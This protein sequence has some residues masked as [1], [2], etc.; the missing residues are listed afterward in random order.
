MLWSAARNVLF[1]FFWV[2]LACDLRQ[3]GRVL[4]LSVKILLL[5]GVLAVSV[6][7]RVIWTLSQPE[8]LSDRQLLEDKQLHSIR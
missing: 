6:S 2:V 3:N 4:K 1:L 5:L 7:D 8:Q